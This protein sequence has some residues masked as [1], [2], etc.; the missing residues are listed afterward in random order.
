MLHIL[1]RSEKFQAWSIPDSDKNF[2]KHE[3]L[4]LCKVNAICKYNNCVLD[5]VITTN[6][7]LQHNLHNYFVYK[8]RCLTK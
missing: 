2:T 3:L 7:L 1:W 4:V 6:Y 8:H 5:T